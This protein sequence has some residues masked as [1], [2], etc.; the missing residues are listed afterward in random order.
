M[1][2]SKCCNSWPWSTNRFPRCSL[3]YSRDTCFSFL[4]TC[5][6][7]S[8]IFRV[9]VKSLY[10]IVSYRIVSLIWS[11]P[12]SWSWCFRVSVLVSVSVLNYWVLT[13][14]SKPE[15]RKW[16]M[17]SITAPVK[18]QIPTTSSKP[19]TA[20]YGDSEQGRLHHISDGAK[21]TMEKVRG[22]VFTSFCGI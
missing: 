12:W 10:R 16:C 19:A 18:A 20:T 11:W 4:A 22:K 21:C 5:A 8:C 15:Y 6:R 14:E 9:H 1:T 13:L 7:L 17:Y 3:F 2:T